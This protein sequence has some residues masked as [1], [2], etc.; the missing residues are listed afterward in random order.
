MFGTYFS[1]L[2]WALRIFDKNL[3]QEYLELRENNNCRM[4]NI[5]F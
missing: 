1:S 5:A 3:R 4:E 2:E